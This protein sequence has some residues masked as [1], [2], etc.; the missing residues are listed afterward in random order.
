[1]LPSWASLSSDNR[2]DISQ[3]HD[4]S[5]GSVLSGRIVEE[6]RA[7]MTAEYFSWKSIFGVELSNR[8]RSGRAGGGG[9]ICDIGLY[10]LLRID[11]LIEF[12][13]SDKAQFQRG[14]LQRQ[15]VIH[16]IVGDF[17]RL[18]VADNWRK[19]R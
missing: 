3:T 2:S 4:V 17:R 19:C 14:S 11:D 6:E 8:R 18:V 15:I 5:Q 9:V 13:P 7:T 1:M 12:G 10:H 16:S